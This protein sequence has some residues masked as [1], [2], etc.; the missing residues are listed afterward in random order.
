[1]ASQP[2]NTGMVVLET[3]AGSGNLTVTSVQRPTS[4]ADILRAVAVSDEY[5]LAID[6]PLGWPIAFRHQ[7][8]EWTI[9]TWSSEQRDQLMYRATDAYLR[10]HGLGQPMSVSANLIAIPTMRT[11][12]LLQKLG[13]LALDGSAGV[14]ETYPAA[15]LRAWGLDQIPYK[16]S[17][18]SEEG[19]QELLNALTVRWNLAVPDRSALVNSDHTLD[20]L[21]CALTVH[22]VVREGISIPPEHREEARVEGWIH[23]PRD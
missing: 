4:D 16:G 2:A 21:I 14:F 22:M 23:V 3:T 10:A 11:K 18:G 13:I 7:M 20:A 19:R 12:A 8:E 6:A 9:E 1:M 17:K 15:T 5:L